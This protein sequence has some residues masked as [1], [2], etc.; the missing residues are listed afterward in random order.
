[1]KTSSLRLVSIAL[2]A[3]AA[4]CG[5]PPPPVVPTPPPPTTA[6]PPPPPAPTAEA[7]RPE[8]PDADFR[9]APP[10]AGPRVVFKPPSVETFALKNGVKVLLVQRHDLPVVS[11]RVVS[12]VGAGDID[13]RP[14]A[15]SFVGSMMEQGTKTRS[16]LQVSDDYDAVGAQHGA[17]FDWDSGGASVRV[18]TSGLPSA[19]AV[20]ADVVLAP[21]FP[22][23]EIE[24]LRSRWIAGL[25]Q[26]KQSSG[27]MAQNA[28][29]A[30]VFGRGHPYGHSMSGEID[31]VKKITRAELAKIHTAAFAPSRIAIAVCGD[32][33]QNEIA[34]ALEKT[35]GAAKAEPGAATV[36]PVPKPAAPKKDAPRLTFVDRPNATQSQIYV[37][38][39]GLPHATKDREAVWVMNAILGGTFS[40]RIN[41]NLR[42]KNAYTYGARS[43]FSMRHGAGPFAA[44]AAVHTDKTAPAIG[45]VFHELNALLSGGVSPSELEGAKDSIKL[46]MPARFETTG[47]VTSA[48]AELFVYDLPA[49]DFEK[50]LVRVDAV[51]EAD[52]KRVAQ[53]YLHP[54]AMRVIVVGDGAKVESTLETLHLGAPQKLDP[55]GN[56]VK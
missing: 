35:F 54:R 44:G 5:D 27:A 46:A 20:L 1:M 37:A 42:E 50:R 9:K 6:P 48:L 8:T 51:S 11:V 53:A 10:A 49:D 52:V 55:Y 22:D 7:P 4:A 21:T 36:R 31:D 30:V 45:E 41:M 2:V 17:W 26:E 14:G 13:A 33:T 15:V 3:V 38:E 12:K 24:R 25:Q 23:A 18:P 19:L 39:V 28:L 29:A 32:V 47:D 34:P 56:A 16:A 40:S 43:Y